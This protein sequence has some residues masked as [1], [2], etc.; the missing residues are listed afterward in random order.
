MFTNLLKTN[1][2]IYFTLSVFVLILLVLACT[3]D[4]LCPETQLTT[5]KMIVLFKNV[6]NPLESK[7]VSGLSVLTY[8]DSLTIAITSNDSIVLPL[9]TNTD[10]TKFL[11]TKDNDDENLKNT[12]TITINYQ[13]ENVYVNRAC[14]F[15]TIFTNVSAIISEETE[16]TNWIQTFTISNNT[17]ENEDQAHSTILH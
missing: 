3:K 9:R 7:A 15:K 11:F 17:I 14:S 8:G 16:N 2:I 13:R 6:N 4:D 5:P 12:D 10:Q 1:R